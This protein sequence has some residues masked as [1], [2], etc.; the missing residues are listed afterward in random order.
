[1]LFLGLPGGSFWVPW[2]LVVLRSKTL[3][4]TECM[5]DGV[6]MVLAAAGGA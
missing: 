1:M 2:L 5:D 4:A 3:L 6:V